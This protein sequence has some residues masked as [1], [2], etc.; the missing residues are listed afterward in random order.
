MADSEDPLRMGLTFQ[1]AAIGIAAVVFSFLVALFVFADHDQPGEIIVAPV[2]ALIYLYQGPS[3]RSAGISG[4]SF[5][6]PYSSSGRPREELG[7][8]AQRWRKGRA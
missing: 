5:K 8:D 4:V 7:E 6:S 3:S 1:I 2:V